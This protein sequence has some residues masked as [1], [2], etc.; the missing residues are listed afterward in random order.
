MPRLPGDL[1]R[2]L[3][4]LRGP[5]NA[6]A[7]HAEV[8]KR[9]VRD[10]PVASDSARTI[11]QELERLAQMLAA[12]GEVLSVERGESRR[13]NLREVAEAALE[14]AHLKDV[15]VASAV[16]PDV[17]GDPALLARAVAHLVENA[18]D[19]TQEAGA[20]TPPPEVSVETRAESTVALVVRDFGPGIKSTNPKV[21]IRLHQS[22]KPGHQGTGLITVERIARLHGGSL[23]FE[24]PGRGT[25][26][27]LVLPTD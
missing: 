20:G 10:D 16:W 7:M 2:V 27:L 11:Q 1:D 18:L 4:D 15:T 22:S 24:A 8:L 21:V 25:R 19:A 3:H 14:R 12:A 9:V 5:L 17:H 13:V 6:I 23:Q 26:A